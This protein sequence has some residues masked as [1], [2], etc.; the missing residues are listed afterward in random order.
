MAILNSPHIAHSSSS[1]KKN[2]PIRISRKKILRQNKNERKKNLMN[3]YHL[4]KEKQEK[5]THK[6]MAAF[7]WLSLPIKHSQRHG[8]E[9]VYYLS[10]FDLHFRCFIGKR[11]FSSII[12]EPIKAIHCVS[13]L[14]SSHIHWFFSLS[15]EEKNEK[16]KNFLLLK[17]R[18]DFVW[19]AW[20]ESKTKEKEEGKKSMGRSITRCFVFY[21]PYYYSPALR[22]W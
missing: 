9:D 22:E 20:N 1:R 11:K 6:L 8:E 3:F 12:I 16:K 7:S 19:W 14:P 13:H 17:L 2:L 21:A 15:E 18:F 5:L 4:R 10:D